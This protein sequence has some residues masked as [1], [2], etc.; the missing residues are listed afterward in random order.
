VILLREKLIYEAIVDHP[1][2]HRQAE[3]NFYNAAL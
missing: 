3:R 1:I 2:Q